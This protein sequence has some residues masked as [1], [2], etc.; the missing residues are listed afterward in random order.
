MTSELLTQTAVAKLTPVISAVTIAM[1]THTMSIVVSGP[2]LKSDNLE[3]LV[4]RD[5]EASFATY[6]TPYIKAAYSV[7][8]TL[9]YASLAAIND[10][11][12]VT[13]KNG[14]PVAL[15]KTTGTI[16]CAVAPA[17]TPPPASSPDT[18]VTYDLKFEFTVPGQTLTKSD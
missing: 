9:T 15:K 13:T 2:F 5:I 7:P 17:Q 4:Q 12:E 10:L 18:A 16:T 6:K 3:V 14:E 1:P 11:S 8:G